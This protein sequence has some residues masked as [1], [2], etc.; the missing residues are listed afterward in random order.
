MLVIGGC[1][2]RLAKTVSDGSPLTSTAPHADSTR[3]DPPRV[4]ASLTLRARP[5]ARYCDA[6]GMS[7]APCHGH[8]RPVTAEPQRLLQVAF[9]AARPTARQRWY[10]WNLTSP[11][12]CSEPGASGHSLGPVQTGKRVVFDVL[13]PPGCHGT[14]HVFVLYVTDSLADCERFALVGRAQLPVP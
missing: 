14:A 4:A 9:T 13:I 10:A 3:A 1:G 2:A 11:R 5:I 6:G 7:L 12:G 8:Q